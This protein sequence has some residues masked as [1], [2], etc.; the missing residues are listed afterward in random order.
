MK[1]YIKR[2]DGIS[3]KIRKIDVLF[4]ESSVK[5]IMEKKGVLLREAERLLMQVSMT[6]DENK[7]ESV[8]L[9]EL[10]GSWLI[11]AGSDFDEEYGDIVLQP[12]LFVI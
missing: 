7:Q 12:A 6:I 8:F 11:L 10:N 5:K 1:N 3:R 2:K 4:P 9:S